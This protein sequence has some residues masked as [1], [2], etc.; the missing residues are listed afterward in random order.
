MQEREKAR[1]RARVVLGRHDVGEIADET[2]GAR[3]FH[4]LA[5]GEP[6]KIGPG[7][8]QRFQ[9]RLALGGLVVLL[10]QLFQD[11]PG[12]FI[13]VLIDVLEQLLPGFEISDVAL[14][15]G[16]LDVCPPDIDR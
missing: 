11:P 15:T 4:G 10:E 1:L 6:R 8:L 9:Q 2:V 14:I 5:L 7:P 3:V 16:T 13:V 12:L